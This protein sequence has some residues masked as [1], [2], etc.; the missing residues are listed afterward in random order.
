MIQDFLGGI[1]IMIKGILIREMKTY[2][3]TSLDEVFEVLD[4]RFLDYNWLF[5]MYELHPNPEEIPF[6]KDYVWLDGHTMNRIARE[7]QMQV[8][9]GVLTAYKKDIKLEQVL[10]HELPWADGNAEI[11]NPKLSMQN[12]LSEIEIIPWDSSL[13]VI[14]ANSEEI[15]ND[16]KKEYPVSIDLEEYNNM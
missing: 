12:P 16:F 9:W 1:R 11:W 5:S 8:I 10:E 4:N 15:I 13:L 14:K 2:G 3:F 6:S 7:H